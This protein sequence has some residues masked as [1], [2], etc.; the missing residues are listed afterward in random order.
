[1]QQPMTLI[2]KHDLDM[3][4]MSQYTKYL[5]QRSFSLNAIGRPHWPHRH[6]DTHTHTHTPIECST[7]TT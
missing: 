2:F 5:G 4:R 1:M 7:W 3:V 6:T